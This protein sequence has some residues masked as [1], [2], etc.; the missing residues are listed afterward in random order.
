MLL[1]GRFELSETPKMPETKIDV[2]S[3]L[4]TITTEG[5]NDP[6]CVCAYCGKDSPRSM[7]VYCGCGVCHYTRSICARC[8]IKCDHCP[9]VM[10]PSHAYYCSGRRTRGCEGVFCY[11][12]LN[13]CEFYEHDYPDEDV[14][15]RSDEKEPKQAVNRWCPSCC[16]RYVGVEKDVIYRCQKHIY[17]PS[18]SSTPMMCYD[19]KDE[20]TLTENALTREYLDRKSK[21]S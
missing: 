13:M 1:F 16:V 10:M 20:K 12:C 14:Y 19:E 5:K 18:P 6:L 9:R 15:R 21:L 3:V 11:P 8:S 7:T 4:Q 17:L 2:C